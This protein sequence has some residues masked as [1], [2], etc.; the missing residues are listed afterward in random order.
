MEPVQLKVDEPLTV[1]SGVDT[2]PVN[3]VLEPLQIVIGD[4]EAV[5]AGN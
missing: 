4:A 5:T 2:V 3:C 1:S